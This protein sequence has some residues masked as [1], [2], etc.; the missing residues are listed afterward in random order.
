M[1]RGPRRAPATTRGELCH[2]MGL[3]KAQTRDLKIPAWLVGFLPRNR[4]NRAPFEFV[5]FET[6]G[7][8]FIFAA[9]SAESRATSGDTSRAR[10]VSSSRAM[11][12]L[13]LQGA[14]LCS[15]REPSSPEASAGLS[16]PCHG[17]ETPVSTECASSRRAAARRA[18]TVLGEF[19]QAFPCFFSMPAALA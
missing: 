9:S 17:R 15:D 16:L 11:I 6:V 14:C 13:M 19:I 2:E 8:R 3:R 10:F 12:L 7:S 18:H 1:E 5:K 4:K